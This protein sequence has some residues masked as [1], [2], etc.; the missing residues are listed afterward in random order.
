SAREKLQLAD[1]E[2]VALTR[3]ESEPRRMAPLGMKTIG[4]TA[5]IEARRSRARA[6]E[7]RARRDGEARRARSV[8]L[9]ARAL[10]GS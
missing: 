8:R 10:E 7:A 9:R 5:E 1:D 4:D 3:L 6:D 2:V